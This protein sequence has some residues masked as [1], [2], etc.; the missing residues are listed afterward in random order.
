M[1]LNVTWQLYD[2]STNCSNMPITS[3]LRRL[4]L[5]LMLS[6]Q[7]LEETLGHASGPLKGIR[8]C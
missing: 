8:K 6:F 3:D 1:S 7:V 5:S 2:V 4:K